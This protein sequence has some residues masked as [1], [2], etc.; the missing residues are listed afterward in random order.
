MHDSL[1]LWGRLVAR[2][3]D[4]PAVASVA[5][6]GFTARS[7]H[8]CLRLRMRRRALIA[9][10]RDG[11]RLFRDW[12]R[13]LQAQF[14]LTRPISFVDTFTNRQ[15]LNIVHLPR[16]LQPYQAEFGDEYIFA[17]VCTAARARPTDFDM[18]RL[19]G[20]PLV[21]ISFGTLHNPGLAF[22]RAGV[23]ALTEQ[24][25]QSVLVLSP[26]IVARD[27][28]TVPD[29]VIVLESGTAPQLAL[30]AR[31]AVF[32]TH[33]GGGGLREGAWHGVPMV[34]VPQTYEQEILSAHLE[35]QQGGV[36]LV[37]EQVDGGTLRMAIARTMT[38]QHIRM[39][40]ERLA[41]ASRAA[42][43]AVRAADAILAY[44]AKRKVSP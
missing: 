34:A 12:R 15:P 7:F 26:G 43:G 42:G 44:A 39:G 16:A 27:L 30:L 32:V 17:G 20:R 8:Q 35:T 14:A 28:G 19:D 13:G 2:A 4:I 3:L 5:T 33:G 11:L 6:A 21:Y 38:D 24:P 25:W 41:E 10:A 29:N 1:C 36:M 31:A 18:A 22:F 9:E 40:S 37:P 23:A